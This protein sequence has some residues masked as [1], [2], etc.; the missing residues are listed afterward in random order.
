MDTPL[1][2][3]TTWRE[4]EFFLKNHCRKVKWYSPSPHPL[5]LGDLIYKS[6]PDSTYS[7]PT[8]NYNSTQP[9]LSNLTLPNLT[10]PNLTLP[11]LTLPN[12]TLPNLTLPNLTL[13]NLTLPNLTL[14]NLTLP[15][16]TLPN[17]T[18]PNLTLPNLTLPNFKGALCWSIL[19]QCMPRNR[20][21]ALEPKKCSAQDL[22]FC[23]GILNRS[24]YRWICS[25]NSTVG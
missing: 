24:S 18:L 10:L 22:G 16:L 19:V 15:N 9:T 20:S 4:V 25:F 1:P 8:Y 14:P 21:G 5:T 6:N 2:P 17:L 3:S 7:N 11:N 12:L 13:P 23:D